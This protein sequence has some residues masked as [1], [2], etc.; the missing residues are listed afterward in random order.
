[1]GA[2]LA[3]VAEVDQ[4]VE[5][6]VGLQPDVA[7]LAAVAAVG[8]AERDELLAAEAHAT[9]AAVAGADGDLCFVDEFHWGAGMRGMGNE[10]NVSVREPWSRGDRTFPSFPSLPSFPHHKRKAP[11]KR[12]PSRCVP[13]RSGGRDDAHRAALLRALGGELHRAVDQREQGVV[14]AE[15][16]ARTRMELGAALADDDVAGL[17]RLAAVHLHAEVLR[18]GVAAVARGT[19]ALF[20][21]HD[22]VSCLLLL[23]PGDAGD[24]DFGVVLPVAH[25]LAMVLAAA[26]LDDADLV[27][28][29]VRDDLGGDGGALEL[30]ADLDA[31]GVAEHQQVAEGDLVADFRR[32]QLD[33]QRLAFHHPVLLA[34][35][36]HDC[37]HVRASL[38]LRPLRAWIFCRS[39]CPAG[40]MG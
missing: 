1:L 30:V 19:Y 28:A 35:S 40:P 10:G 32:Q 17:D 24:L 22:C 7:A 37:A 38:V 27:G 15:A 18:V 14:A 29:A 20:M 8:A 26:E 31:I 16:D 11:P 33:A 39:S 13:A 2:E 6:L 21:C 5:V 36:N 3:L 12:G 25:L 9:V 23:G 4:G 34:A